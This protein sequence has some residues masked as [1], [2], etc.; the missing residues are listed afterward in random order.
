MANTLAYFKTELI[1]TSKCFT[2]PAQGEWTMSNGIE[3]NMMQI[4]I[5]VFV[6]LLSS[7][8]VLHLCDRNKRT[9]MRVQPQT[10]TNERKHNII[11]SVQTILFKGQVL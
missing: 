10:W 4:T 1:T 11:S 5:K 8:T 3:R 7:K 2:E 6:A 9:K